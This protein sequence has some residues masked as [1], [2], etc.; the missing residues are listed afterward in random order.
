[1]EAVADHQLEVGEK[2][3]GARALVGVQ[4]LPHRQEVHGLLDDRRVGR[5]V[6]RSPVYEREWSEK[7]PIKKIMPD[8][9]MGS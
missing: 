8:V 7:V 9:P 4:P 3:L 1:M 5:D 2:C 6:E